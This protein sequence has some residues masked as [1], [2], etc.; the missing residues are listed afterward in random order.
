MVNNADVGGLFRRNLGWHDLSL[1][2]GIK[3]YC[4]L[5]EAVVG[6]ESQK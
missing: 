5:T 3:I 4:S 6:A 1:L 2:A